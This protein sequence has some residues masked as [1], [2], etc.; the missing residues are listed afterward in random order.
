VI[1]D[2]TLVEIKADLTRSFLTV[3]LYSIRYTDMMMPFL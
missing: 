1:K 2:R 3:G